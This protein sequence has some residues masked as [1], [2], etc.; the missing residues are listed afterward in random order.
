VWSPYKVGLIE[1][2]DKVQKRATK[3]VSAC[4]KLSYCD[5]LKYLDILTLKY[6]RYVQS[7]DYRGDMIE[8][9]KILHDNLNCAVIDAMMASMTA[10]FLLLWL[11]VTSR[12]QGE[13]ILN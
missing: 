8:T 11:A 4:S 5:R 13:T 9:Y 3:M 2:L 10:Q 12:L 7:T 6:R 1:M